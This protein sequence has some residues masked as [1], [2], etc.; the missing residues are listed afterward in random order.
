MA[1]F[2]SAFEIMLVNEGGYVLHEVAG[3]TGGMTY[4]G[5][6]RNK[7]PHWKGWA[8]ID[9]K[10]L[11]GPLTKLVRDFYKIEFWDRIR[12]D[13]IQEQDIANSIF[14]FGVNSG[15]GIAI[16][17]A[18]LVV[19]ATPDGSLGPK[20]VGLLNQQNPIDFCK[21]YALIKIAR[22]A[23][24]C[25]KNRTKSKFLLGWINRTMAGLK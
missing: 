23:A 14:N 3:D 24:I 6:A 7:N 12:G 16:K 5:I 8:Y 11:G 21:S 15:V 1:N 9:N 2:E 17:L 19:G 25:N 10:E 22:Y 4:A 13:E 20:T 18:Q